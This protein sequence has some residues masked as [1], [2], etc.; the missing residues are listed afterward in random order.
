MDTKL[1][2]PPS[3]PVSIVELAEKYWDPVNDFVLGVYQKLNKNGRTEEQVFESSYWG[4]LI[5]FI[6]MDLF[7]SRGVDVERQLIE[8]R[9]LSYDFLIKVKNG[10]PLKI[11]SKTY[12]IKLKNRTPQIPNSFYID[13]K[14]F[15][16]PDIY[17]ISE[18]N[19]IKKEIRT[20][21]FISHYD[22]KKII[23]TLPVWQKK[24]HSNVYQIKLEYLTPIEHLIP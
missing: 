15:S 24:E 8:P 20:V 7:K 5:E 4:T 6:Q 16:T 1:N 17:I 13:Y 12:T 23:S 19:N 21:G 3:S 18:I 11:D 9:D 14:T 2:F 22:L 10:R